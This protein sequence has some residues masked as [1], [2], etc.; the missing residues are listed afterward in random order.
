MSIKA[1]VLIGT[2]WKDG[3]SWPN[4]LDTTLDYLNGS[5]NV[6]LVNEG[7]YFYSL[8]HSSMESW[9]GSATGEYCHG[10]SFVERE[11]IFFSRQPGRGFAVVSQAAVTAE[12][13]RQIILSKNKNK[14]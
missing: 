9:L 12:T 7:L 10:S 2:F 4:S 8:C 13:L 14:T 11:I 5:S 6:F 3:R 1:K